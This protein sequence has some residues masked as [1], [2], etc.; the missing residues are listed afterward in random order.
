MFPQKTII[1]VTGANGQLGKEFRRLAELQMEMEFLFTTRDTLDITSPSEV[2]HV[3]KKFRPDF[4]INCAAYTHVDRA[5]TDSESAYHVNSH[6]VTQLVNACQLY[7]CRLVHFSTDYVYDSAVDRPILETDVCSPRSIYGKSKRAGEL[8]LEQSRIDWINIRVSWLYSTFNSNFVKTMLRLG[9]ERT[10]LN[11]V[12][13]Q[14]GAPTNARDLAGVVIKIL[15]SDLESKICQHYNFCN[16][17]QTNWADYARL[18]FDRSGMTCRVNG[19]STED[20]NAAAPRP[21]WSVMSTDKIS[22][23]FGV[24][25]PEWKESLYSCMDELITS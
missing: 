17:G 6:G 11:V 2:F 13:D 15:R 4:C 5:E 23:A 25:I 7:D 21:K 19:I 3:F 12:N 18:I 16:L 24:D 8:V 9:N 10:E 20:Y 14:I 1:I 22:S